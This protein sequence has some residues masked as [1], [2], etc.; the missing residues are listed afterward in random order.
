ML[1]HIFLTVSDTDRSV[2]FYEKVLPV[3]GITRRLDYDGKDGPPGHPDLKGF[4]ANGRVFFWLRQGTPAP[5]AVHVGFVADSEDMVTS[6][7]SA[8]LGAGATA[9][10]APGP[11]LHYDPRY[12]AAQV[13]DPDGYSLEFVYKPWQHGS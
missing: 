10:H 8:A 6:G 7:Y 5:G 9:I 4:G 3:L 2:A 12:Y 1:D 11:Q 13:R